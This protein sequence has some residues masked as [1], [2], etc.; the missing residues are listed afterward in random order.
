MLRGIKYIEDVS[1]TKQQSNL[2]LKTG[3]ER[4]INLDK[5]RNWIQEGYDEKE[6]VYVGSFKLFTQFTGKKGKSLVEPEKETFCS[7]NI[8]HVA[9]FIMNMLFPK[10]LDPET[11]VQE[12]PYTKK[13]YLNQPF[14]IYTIP[15][16]KEQR[17]FENTVTTGIKLSRDIKVLVTKDMITKTTL[18]E[19]LQSLGIKIKIADGKDEQLRKKAI[20]DLLIALKIYKKQTS[21]KN[22]P[23][24][25]C[26]NFD[27]FADSGDF[28]KYFDHFIVGGIA[29]LPVVSID[30][31]KIIIPDEDSSNLDVNEQIEIWYKQFIEDINKTIKI[32]N[33]EFVDLRIPM[34]KWVAGLWYKNSNT[35]SVTKEIGTEGFADWYKN[36]FNDKS[37]KSKDV[38]KTYLTEDEMSDDLL[39]KLDY[40]LKHPNKE[41]VSKAVQNCTK[42]VPS[43]KKGT[44]KHITSVLI[45]LFT[46]VEKE[47]LR[48]DKD[49]HL[50]TIFKESPKLGLKIP[51]IKEIFSLAKS[52][53]IK[54]D[55]NDTEYPLTFTTNSFFRDIDSENYAPSLKS[56]GYLSIEDVKN[57][58][59]VTPNIL[60]FGNLFDAEELVHNQLYAG[61]YIYLSD[62]PK[63]KPTEQEE[64]NSK[65]VEFL[66]GCEYAAYSLNYQEGYLIGYQWDIIEEI[67][68]T[69]KNHEK[70]QNSGTESFSEEDNH[71][72]DYKDV[73]HLDLVNLHETSGKMSP[74]GFET[75][76]FYID[77]SKQIAME[78]LK[79]EHQTD[80]ILPDVLSYVKIPHTYT[81]ENLDLF[82]SGY[83]NCHKSLYEDMKFFLTNPAVNTNILSE[84]SVC[85]F[86]KLF[87]ES[88]ILLPLN[89]LHYTD[90]TALE[91]YQNIVS[92]IHDSKEYN[93]LQDVTYS[94]KLQTLSSN[95]NETATKLINLIK[96]YADT[97]EEM[98][99]IQKYIKNVI[100]YYQE[101]KD[102]DCLY[103][104]NYKE[105][106]SFNKK[107]K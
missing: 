103:D 8:K 79:E 43:G 81:K 39:K 65:R 5:F 44:Y 90:T 88:E 36:L 24:V 106:L 13:Y 92:D 85:I 52:I 38:A 41:L 40:L 51:P 97:F 67:Y 29:I 93:T 70:E 96:R 104:V 63:A 82:V 72:V 56:L 45:K 75:F 32:P 16:L 73:A 57:D 37:K 18:G 71:S 59:F 1:Q 94:E 50:A 91:S 6:V 47:L 17:D 25:N 102:T 58:L 74:V 53:N 33:I 77:K 4:V 35:K 76:S 3:I 55:F 62:D 60:K 21:P 83:T 2:S 68:K 86:T 14:Y 10:V 95:G 22:Q 107:N 64:V 49:G 48:C 98:Y 61:S 87:K 42:G 34:R 7:R 100:P 9:A 101:Y 27:S 26:I 54:V 23:L 78:Y 84:Q 69:V 19:F 89:D 28:Q 11:F 31:A 30:P 20:D 15:N 12:V 80:T 66:E 99:S 105:Y 46:I